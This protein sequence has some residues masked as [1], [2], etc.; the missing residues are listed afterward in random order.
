MKKKLKMRF[1]AAPLNKWKKELNYKLTTE[2][3]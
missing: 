3:Q 1:P 2:E